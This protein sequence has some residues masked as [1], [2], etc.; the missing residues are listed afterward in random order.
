MLD[1]APTNTDA[2]SLNYLTNSIVIKC[3]D[4]SAT[5]VA[6]GALLPC[7]GVVAASLPEADGKGCFQ[8]G[9]IVNGDVVVLG[10]V[11]C[12]GSGAVTVSAAIGADGSIDVK[13]TA[14]GE[15]STT[16]VGELN[17]PAAV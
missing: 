17:I 4:A 6:R 11:C 14:K 10:D 8:V 3:G 15:E 12:S 13:V 2:L 5:V 16:V 1:N 9:A 7:T